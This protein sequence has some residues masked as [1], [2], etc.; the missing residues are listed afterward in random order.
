MRRSLVE[1]ETELDASALDIRVAYIHTYKICTHKND[2]SPGTVLVKKTWLIISHI[3]YRPVRRKC[4]SEQFNLKLNE[5][6]R[7]GLCV[8]K[9][10]YMFEVM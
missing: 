5:G 4:V 2:V 8:M 6:R 9:H 1:A 7:R 10:Q 3:L